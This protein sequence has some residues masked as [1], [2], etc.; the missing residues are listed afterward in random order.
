MSHAKVGAN[1]EYTHWAVLIGV[2]VCGGPEILRQATTDPRP[3]SR[4]LKG[5]VEDVLAIRKFLETE[6]TT[7]VE[8]KITNLTA[9]EGDGDTPKETP[10]HLPSY[11]NICS[12]LEKVVAEGSCG[13]VKH[14]YI[15]FSGHGT[16]TKNGDFGLVLYDPIQPVCLS[17]DKLV[18]YINAMADHGMYVTLVL[19]CCFSGRVKRSD[20]SVTGAVRFI[21][22]NPAMKSES[23]SEDA[24]YEAQPDGL[25]DSSLKLDRILNHQNC[26]VIT[27][28]DPLGRAKEI[29]LPKKKMWRGA[30]SYFL[31]R[32][33]SLLSGKN[34]QITPGT[35]FGHIKAM[36][37][38]YFPQQTP[39]WHGNKDMQTFFQNV[40]GGGGA[41]AVFVK[42][43]YNAADGGIIL[44]A[45][46]AHGV[47][48]GDEY[49]AFPY[50]SPEVLKIES[51]P[52]GNK[53][54]IRLRV[55]SI[56][57]FN[58]VLE[59]I[60][61]E[62]TDKI[63]RDRAASVTWK[64]V[65]VFSSSK[66]RVALTASLP[67]PARK[68]LQDLLQGHPFLQLV[69]CEDM[70]KTCTSYVT[71]EHGFYKIW[72]DTNSGINV[73]PV[74]LFDGK[75]SLGSLASMMGHLAAFKFAEELQNQHPDPIFVNSFKLEL[76]QDH[77]IVDD[78]IQVE[79]GKDLK[80]S[81]TNTGGALIYVS[82]LSFHPSL[83]VRNLLWR[84]GVGYCLRIPLGGKESL[85][86]RMKLP[87]VF[88]EEGKNECQEVIKFFI[89]TNETFF[90]EMA[91]PIPDLSPSN[92]R[93]CTRTNA[94]SS[95][96]KCLEKFTS[97]YSN[98]RNTSSHWATRNFQV[99]IY[100]T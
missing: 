18:K 44:D 37:K 17:G 11:E 46:E 72:G 93:G 67:E 99:K 76:Q 60:S 54:S 80:F 53:D 86:M 4:L 6:S 7:G 68:H 70:T 34:A 78:W 27:A 85:P 24:L 29:W 16:Q 42:I 94:I 57:S 26:I 31:D 62:D 30:L 19:D 38:S 28:C 49:E 100:K 71:K 73:L 25:R 41:G 10:E 32:S 91:L 48:K 66:S 9:T 97:P 39:T 87:E 74:H 88:A 65:K 77:D 21:E 84:D 63:N 92:L 79:H 23:G 5:A 96:S 2:D 47:N 15:H 13:I 51:M 52:D 40:F 90:P 83:E 69:Q 56:S 81:V 50:F 33:L 35:L 14:V 58:S 20:Q 75:D 64:A 12:I 1:P 22:Y 45:G 61:H 43:F 8:I 3:E 55:K 95:L 89:T 98:A 36:F 59:V 82:I